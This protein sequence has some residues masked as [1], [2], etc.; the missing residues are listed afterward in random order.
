MDLVYQKNEILLLEK[1]VNF[2]LLFALN[3]V[4]LLALMQSYIQELSLSCII[5]SINA[6]EFLV[7]APKLFLI[8]D[9][10]RNRLIV[11]GKKFVVTVRDPQLLLRALMCWNF[12][13]AM[14]HLIVLVH[15]PVIRSENYA[16]IAWI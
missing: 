9:Q 2:H 4:T 6:H 5:V 3:L 8:S 14:V 10:I 11:D 15:A 16:A 13:I 7:Y 1:S 12:V